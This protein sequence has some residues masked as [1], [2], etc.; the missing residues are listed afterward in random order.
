MAAAG[1]RGA[2]Q[3]GAMPIMSAARAPYLG[4][5][6]SAHT[7]YKQTAWSLRDILGGESIEDISDS[8]R[9][10][11][12][13]FAAI[14][15]SLG[16][17]I[18]HEKFAGHISR[19]EEITRDMSRVGGHASLSY[20]EDTQSEEAAALSARTSQ[21]ESEI[22]NHT[23]FFDLWW[24]RGI[25]DA[26]AARLAGA[27][28][29]LETRLL[30]KRELA[31]HSLSEAEEKVIN[32]LDVT[33]VSALVKIYDTITN[34]YTYTI[35]VD[36]AEK[37]MGREELTSYVRSS[38]PQY[39]EDAYRA[40]LDRYTG[41]RNV[42]GEIYRNVVLSGRNE[43]ILMRKYDSPIS[44][45]NAGSNLDDSTV[46]SLLD[47]CRE[48]VGVFREYFA[49]K[50]SL[51]GSERLRR[52]DL[53]A[54]LNGADKKYGYGEAAKMV[55]D[56][57]SGF[58]GMLGEYAKR[59]FDEDHIHSTI[60]KGKIS[61]AFCST[62]SPD[63]TPYVLLNYT[64]ETRDVFTMAHELGHAVHSMAAG[65]KSILVQHAPL[66]LAETA[67][68]FSEMLLFDAM[69]GEMGQAEESKVLAGKLDDLYA[70]IPRQAFFTIFETRAHKRLAAG[71]TPGEISDVYAGTLAEQFGDSVDVS[72]DFASE[73]LSIP[74]FYHHPFYCYSYS[75][76]NLL[77]A[78]LFQ[79]HKR[80]GSGFAATYEGI[81]AAGGSRKPEELLAEYGFDI[82]S[83]NFWR[84]G[85]DYVRSLNSRLATLA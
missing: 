58:S 10:K 6:K 80:E 8:L 50:A 15:D 68:T 23:V 74:H 12:S 63:I 55:L 19:M 42:L 43:Y 9:R 49:Q 18:S 67:S 26:D 16:G 5:P 35:K 78:S 13:A 66:P 56:T 62:I 69:S 4:K 30:H 76:G 34:A 75:F 32:L 28:G 40:I 53:Y 37:T 2:V 29:D 17:D 7:V 85:F 1:Y 72:G 14:K 36:G 51:L 81:L 45:M 33:G 77:A 60:Q 71:A 70:T 24:K 54:P 57:L 21:L 73:W 79:R 59:V 38:V 52:Y 47:A 27:S 22:S 39:R 83:A 3:D 48:S 44:V 41:S 20:T 65:S 25:G 82:G 46:E 64:G 31:R 11:A 61:G 84:E